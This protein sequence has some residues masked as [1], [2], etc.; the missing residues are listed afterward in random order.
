L[1]R[2]GHCLRE[3]EKRF[4]FRCIIRLPIGPLP[5]KLS[6]DDVIKT[7]FDRVIDTWGGCGVARLL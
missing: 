2:V 6:D 3:R 4:I 5:E 7:R 1:R